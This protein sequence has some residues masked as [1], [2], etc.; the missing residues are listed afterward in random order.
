MEEEEL[1]NKSLGHSN[2]GLYSV[3]VLGEEGLAHLD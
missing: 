2:E 3:P 1:I